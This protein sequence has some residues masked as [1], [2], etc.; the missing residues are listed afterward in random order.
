MT[1][2]LCTILESTC[3]EAFPVV[4]GIVYRDD[5]GN[6]M[7]DAGESPIPGATVGDFDAMRYTGT[8][9]YG[10]YSLPLPFGS[11]SIT[12]QPNIQ[13]VLGI[14]PNAHSVSVDTYAQVVPQI[15]FG[16][17][18]DNTVHGADLYVQ[19]DWT[20][21][22]FP[23]LSTAHL[24][25]VGNL[26]EVK[27]GVEVRLSAPSWLNLVTSSPPATVQGSTYVWQLDSLAF[28]EER[29][30]LAVFAIPFGMQNGTPLSL[31]ATVL[32]TQ[33]DLDPSN[34]V[35][36]YGTFVGASFDPNDKQVFPTTLLPEE[37]M[38][39]RTV[40]YRIRFQ[41]T[42]TAPALRVL[43]TDTLS[44]DLDPSTFQLLGSSHPCTW[45]FRDGALHFMFDP[46]FLPDST[47]DE[48]NSHGHVLFKIDTRPGLSV[49][50]SIANT[51]NIYFDLNEP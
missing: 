39:G 34:N 37:G 25:Y 32:P 15:D 42:G 35:N 22:A 51:A 31:V 17:Q 29:L 1:L 44:A 48:E 36:S 30:L 45:F 3:P 21:A 6:G 4:T 43:I 50:E 26:G 28:G 2:P 27:Y 11:Y 20:G 10:R 9:Q 18:V 49:G 14:L 8:D 33:D 24:L 38:E 19:N 16:V 47:M 13:E 41:N 40:D 5:N 7:A 46:I 12:V 23:G